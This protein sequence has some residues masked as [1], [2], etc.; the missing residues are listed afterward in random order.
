MKLRFSKAVES[1]L[2]LPAPELQTSDVIWSKT[3]F[4]ICRSLKGFRC[5]SMG[6]NELVPV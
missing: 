6:L 4:L 5:V 3:S 2:G 1:R